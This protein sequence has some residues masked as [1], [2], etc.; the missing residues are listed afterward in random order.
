M[1]FV[2]I[3]V[4]LTCL[5][6]FVPASVNAQYTVPTDKPESSTGPTLTPETTGQK[7]PQGWTGP[8]NTGQG[9]RPGLK[10]AGPDPAR[11]AICA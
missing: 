5:T 8:T 3:A 7:K 1:K 11:N 2:F 10:P 4:C 9:G 6:T